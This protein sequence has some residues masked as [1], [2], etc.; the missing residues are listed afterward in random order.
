MTG[1]N[2]AY[3]VMVDPLC[4]NNKFYRMTLKGDALVCEYGRVGAKG[5]M[6][7]YPASKWN[8]LYRRK[9]GKGYQDMTDLVAAPTI[10]VQEGA[11][12]YKPID[13]VL[14]RKLVEEFQRYAHQ[15]L[16][17]N[18]EISYKKVT[19]K[20]VDKAQE[21]IEILQKIA[22]T[23]SVD[24]FNEQLLHLFTI[25]PRK[26]VH[27]AS[28]LAMTKKDFDKILQNEQDLL[29]IMRGQVLID[30]KKNTK[31]QTS[32]QQSKDITVLEEQGIEIQQG[33]DKDYE[34]ISK[35]YNGD[36]KIVNVFKAKN[37]KTEAQYQKYIKDHNI[38]NTKLLWH[39]TRNENVWSILGMG[40]L[41]NPKAVITGKMYGHGI[42]FAP[43]AKK[44]LGYTSLSGSYWAR[45][46]D[47]KGYMLIF[48]TAYG[49]PK[50][51]Y[52]YGYTLGSLTHENFKSHFPN[53]DCLHAK[54]G[55]VLRNDEII[56][57]DEHQMTLRY[58]VE[59]QM[60]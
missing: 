19:Q 13:D 15:T 23:K 51:V 20:M 10:D 33:T 8:S 34:A 6:K 16:E 2:F 17:R 41:L 57:Y 11:T 46:N 12:K 50:V 48:E 47:S 5:T 36:Y 40:L 26:M 52:D 9:I 30:N 32:V 27:V 14:V 45:G 25:I 28:H 22:E 60:N 31:K 21:N 55:K 4:N 1:E 29:D 7:T 38:K 56:F 58:I 43:S 44:S 42:Y 59:F 3:L 35:M 39:G 49:T 54:A 24:A 18:Y 53:Y 37:K